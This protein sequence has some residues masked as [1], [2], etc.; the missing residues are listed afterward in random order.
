MNL[1]INPYILLGLINMKLRDYY[2][3]LEDLVEVENIDIDLLISKLDSIG[4]IYNKE[5]NQFISKEA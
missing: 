4:Y 1:N 2:K 3:N 5:T